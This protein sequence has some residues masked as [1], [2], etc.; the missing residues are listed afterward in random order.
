MHMIIC[1]LV[2]ASTAEQALAAGQHVFDRLVGFGPGSSSI[3][4]YYVTFESEC[5]RVAGK[6]RWGDLPIAAPVNSQAGHRLVENGWQATRA[7]FDR[8]LDRVKEAIESFSDEEI[9]HDKGFSRHAFYKVGSYE[10]P[11]I[12]LYDEAGDGVRTRRRLETIVTGGEDLWVVPADVH[13]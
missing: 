12:F 1:A 13:Y 2:E 7:V 4:D 11:E 3:F 9:L 8:N 5:S 6:G 10:G